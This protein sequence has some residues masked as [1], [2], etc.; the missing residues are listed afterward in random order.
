MDIEIDNGHLSLDFVDTRMGFDPMRQ[1]KLGSAIF[2][3]SG[4]WTMWEAIFC[5]LLQRLLTDPASREIQCRNWSFSG[6][7]NNRNSPN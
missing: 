5:A 3:G 1:D 4:Y 2:G 6:R 7:F